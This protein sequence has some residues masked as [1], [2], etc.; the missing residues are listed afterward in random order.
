MAKDINLEL[1]KFFD[2]LASGMFDGYAGSGEREVA[3]DKLK[4]LLFKDWNKIKMHMI[5]GVFMDVVTKAI[6]KEMIS[7]KIVNK[8]TDDNWITMAR[9]QTQSLG[10]GF[11]SATDIIH[12]YWET[13]HNTDL[14]VPMIKELT[15][16]LFEVALWLCRSEN[17]ELQEFMYRHFEKQTFPRLRGYFFKVHLA[18]S[19]SVSLKMSFYKHIVEKLKHTIAKGTDSECEFITELLEDKAFVE[20][21]IKLG[22]ESKRLYDWT[23]NPMFLP[24][25]VRKIFLVKGGK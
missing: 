16:D 19:W 8:F 21:L 17:P 11:P 24:E 15:N 3:I 9:I 25:A 4:P 20:T 1:S 6:F 22:I 2:D 18:S 7:K 10:E 5:G 23:K 13:N 14:L 12:T